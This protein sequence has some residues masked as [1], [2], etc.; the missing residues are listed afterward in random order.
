MI[1]N[2]A[3]SLGFLK[4][5]NVQTNKRITGS[6]KRRDHKLSENNKKGQY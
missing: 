1:L 6:H 3:F 2:I 5:R 4:Q